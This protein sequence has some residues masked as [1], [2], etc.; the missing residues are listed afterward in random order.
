LRACLWFLPAGTLQQL[1]QPGKGFGRIAN[2]TNFDG[3]AVAHLPP[4]D[5]HLDGPG[6]PG[7]RIELG[8]RVVGADDQEGVAV[9]HQVGAGGGTEVSHGACRKRQRLIHVW[10][11]QEAGGD[12]GIKLLRQGQHLGL[13]VLGALPHQERHLAAGSEH[14]GSPGQVVIVG[15]HSRRLPFGRCDDDAVLLVE[16][17]GRG[18]LDVV[19]NNHDARGAGFEGCAE[20][21]VQHH[22]K[23]LRGA[24]HLRELRR[25]ILEERE[26]VDF[27]H[28]GRPQHTAALLA[29]DGHHGDAIQFGVIEPVEEMHC[30][31]PLGGRHHAHPARVLGV[32]DGHERR[33]FLVPGLHEFDAGSTVT[34]VGAVTA[35]GSAAG[36]AALMLRR[37]APMKPLMPSPL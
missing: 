19:R 28:V 35:A 7:F 1:R 11:A 3:V 16:L 30:A 12:A 22:G 34:A 18:L 33:G 23:L 8:P 26:Q 24:D 15:Q 6:S 9:P 4:V 5:V 20:G 37:S 10:L 27:L 2:E 17:G 31:R 21:A 36:A 14:L 29:D 32:P 13:G 25:H